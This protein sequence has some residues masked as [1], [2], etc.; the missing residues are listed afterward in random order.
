MNDAIAIIGLSFDLPNIKNWHEL[1]ASLSDNASYIGEL[2][3]ARAEEL[4]KVFGAVE[5]ARAGYMNEIDKFDNEYFGFTERESVKTFP[6]H[7]LFLTYAM[8]AFYHAGYNEAALKGSKTGVF[9]TAS[10]TAY[11]NYA[12]VT[13][14]TFSQVDFISGIEGTRLAN[15]LDTRGPV[16]SIDTSCS[17]SLV[18]INAARQSLNNHECDI[19]IV[20]GVK[21]LTLTRESTMKNVVHSKK[22]ECRPFDKEADGMMNGEGAI[23]FVLKRYDDALKNGDA[24]LAEIKGIG[25][26]HGGARIS[27]LT[28]PSSQAQ[29]EVIL[30]AWKNA[31]VGPAQIK[32]IEAHG[33]ATILGDPIEIEGMKEAFYESGVTA[34]NAAC[35]VSSFKGQIGHLDYL[36]GLA[37]LL[38]LV[39]VLNTKVIPLQANLRQLNDYFSI[40]GT[41]LYI[42]A[43]T[44]T[45]PGDD[46]ERIGGVSSFGMTGTN[47][48]VVVSQKE[49]HVPNTAYESA[50]YLQISGKDALQLAGYK[51]YILEKILPLQDIAAIHRVAARLNTVFQIGNENEGIVYTSRESLITA[52]QTASQKPA[53]SRQ[54]L[55]LDLELMTY[56]KDLIKDVFVENDLIKQTWDKHVALPLDSIT[57]SYG[58]NALFQYTIYMYLLEKAGSHLKFITPKG[59]SVLNALVKSEI[60]VAQVASQEGE[61]ASSHHAFDESMFRKYLKENLGSEL[62]TLIDFSGRDKSR[63]DDLGLQLH[64]I[65]GLLTNSS[66]C[67]LYADILETGV[68]PLKPGFNPL[69]DD[70]D[71]PYFN[72]KR[73]WPVVHTQAAGSSTKNTTQTEA[74]A[75][76]AISS[77]AVVK[78][79]R[80]SWALILERSDFSNEESF[81]DL[82]GTSLAALDMIDEIEKQIKGVKIPYES[83]YTNATVS[84]LTASILR[85]L[86]IVPVPVPEDAG[87]SSGRP[88]KAAIEDIVRSSWTLIL[89]TSDFKDHDSFFDTGG[90]SLSAL[91]MID[92]IEK[93]I[94]GIKIPYEDIYTC[95]TVAK[96]SNRILSQLGNVT[97]AEAK[98]TSLQDTRAREEKYVSLLNDIKKETFLRHV[99]ENILITG[100]TGLLGMNI[101]HYLISST[102][103]R[104][105][106]L[107][108]KESYGSAEE[109]F[110][111]VYGQYFEITDKDRVVVI[112]GDLYREGLGFRQQEEWFATIEMIIHVAGSPQFVSQKAAD[113]HINFLG[114]KHIVDWANKQDVKKLSFISTI[115]I[116]G[117]TMPE[118]IEN[119]YET[120]TNLGQDSEQLIHSASK[121]KA[122]EY[123]RD[124]YKY[125][126][127]IFR[128]P[129][130]GGRLDDG[131]F[132]TNLEKNLMWLRLRSLSAMKYYCEE[133]LNRNS[134]IGLMPVDVIARLIAE[135]SFTDIA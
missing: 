123:I 102:K 128:I 61:H 62:L 67:Q 54:L 34:D 77:E 33:T 60:T 107:V 14:L 11:H 27:S 6:E 71:L 84:L 5:M 99:P 51:Q 120:D 59:G 49:C 12:S 114:T 25:I 20:G 130:I 52:L 45:W 125:K 44:G 126:G 115:G 19:A 117:K 50:Y 79:V 97:V 110:W 57:H 16:I 101:L 109:R 32:Y 92:E 46:E 122:E 95:D 75:V 65:D 80:E 40:E 82:G 83:I 131:N 23:F 39:A 29:K 72:L 35:G 90:T 48:H 2:P 85:Q 28:A 91:D 74:P 104:L 127:R 10:R 24:I 112:E 4:R 42:P 93:R 1:V 31:K 118:G 64:V 36:S 55:L 38:R 53:G 15:F 106:C 58:L 116:V 8:K 87:K 100:A 26:N 18:A 134:G 73:F 94:E 22:E 37:G 121:L 56:P 103:S 124:H 66:R 135:I 96:L 7:R 47:V 41:G 70:I 21:I 113:E 119:F 89:E 88:G 132:A 63:F 81:F 69:S 86:A 76:P 98:V 133:L 17:S 13:D 43:S 30:Q 108:R 68:K 78:A 105:Y 3:H 9:F 129:N 111:S